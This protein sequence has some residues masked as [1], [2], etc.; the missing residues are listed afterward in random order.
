MKRITAILMSVLMMLAAFPSAVAEE[1]GG[2]TVIDNNI[3][4]SLSRLNR[5]DHRFL[6]SFR[7]VSIR[8]DIE[9]HL[10]E[11]ELVR[12]DILMLYILSIDEKLQL[13]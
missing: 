4:D 9:Q 2:L 5:I 3:S 13:L 7:A 8:Q 1:N 11:T 6:F 10:V 12:D